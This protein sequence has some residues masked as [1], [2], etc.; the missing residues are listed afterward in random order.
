MTEGECRP[1]PQ[2]IA[3][4]NVTSCQRL[5]IDVFLQVIELGEELD[6]GRQ[7]LATER[8]KCVHTNVCCR[9]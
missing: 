9:P 2:H 6:D 7:S 4:L 1:T 8:Y 3:S 5:C